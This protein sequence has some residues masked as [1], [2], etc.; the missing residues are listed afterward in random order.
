MRGWKKLLIC[1][2]YVVC[3]GVGGGWL[4]CHSQPLH[5]LLHMSVG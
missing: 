1:A 2:D 3:G 5:L 4:I